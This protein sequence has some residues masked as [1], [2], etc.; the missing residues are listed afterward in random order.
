[1]TNMIVHGRITRDKYSVPVD[2][3]KGV[4]ITAT[5]VRLIL[6]EKLKLDNGLFKYDA[7]D[8]LETLDELNDQYRSLVQ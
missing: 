8:T 7:I 2:K 4:Q 3:I 6:T 5:G 1:M